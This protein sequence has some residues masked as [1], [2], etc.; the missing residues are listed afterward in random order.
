MDFRISW[1]E[2]ANQFHRPI[3]RRNYSFSFS[4]AHVMW[5]CGDIL[6]G[7]CSIVRLTFYSCRC[8]GSWGTAGGAAGD[9]AARAHIHPAAE[10]RG[11]SHCSQLITS[12]QQRQWVSWLTHNFSAPAGGA[13]DLCAYDTVSQAPLVSVSWSLIS[14]NRS[15]AGP[16]PPSVHWPTN[17]EW[18]HNFQQVNSKNFSKWNL[19]LC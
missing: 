2:A 8:R 7:S 19:K 13:V 12:V 3:I 6:A 15:I 16:S 10:Q 11:S 1:I 4:R 5:L 9:E 17:L 18:H 14:N